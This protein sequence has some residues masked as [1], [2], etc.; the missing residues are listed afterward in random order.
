MFTGAPE[1]KIDPTTTLPINK[2]IFFEASAAFEIR[3]SS[4]IPQLFCKL[5]EIRSDR[6]YVTLN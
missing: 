5:R 3:V 2:K 4:S 1:A 6:C